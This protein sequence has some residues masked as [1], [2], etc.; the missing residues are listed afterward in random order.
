LPTLSV[1]T[2]LCIPNSPV[3][4]GEESVG[5]IPFQEK[6]P[7]VSYREW[8]A[9]PEGLLFQNWSKQMEQITALSKVGFAHAWLGGSQTII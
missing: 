1:I 7:A 2:Q 8:L 6:A 5:Q 9:S 3:P 4:P